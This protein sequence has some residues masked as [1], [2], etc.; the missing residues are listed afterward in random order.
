M[1]FPAV[2]PRHAEG[3][4]RM[5]YLKEKESHSMQWSE[6]RESRSALWLTSKST[7]PFIASEARGGKPPG[8]SQMTPNTAP[9]A[10]PVG[11]APPCLDT[12]GRCPLLADKDLGTDSNSLRCLRQPLQWCW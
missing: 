5:Y 10:G 9:R 12:A 8:V 7:P 2:R 4:E 6:W 3:N 1:W 11:V